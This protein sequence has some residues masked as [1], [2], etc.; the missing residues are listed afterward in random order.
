MLRS[1]RARW[2]L[3]PVL[4]QVGLAWGSDSYVAELSPGDAFRA[5]PQIL[6]P[7]LD[8]QGFR[9][10]ANIAGRKTAICDVWWSKQIPAQARSAAPQNLVYGALKTGAFL[11]V[12]SYLAD[13]ED[14]Q[15][16]MVKAG[17]YTM[18]YAELDQN[19]SEQA[20]SPYRDFAILSP[21]WA[22]RAADDIVP[23]EELTKRSRFVSH[24]DGPAVLS[25]VPVNPA[26]KTVPWAVSDDRGF[27]T[28]QVRL[29]QRTGTQEKDMPFA[30]VLVRPPYEN[31][32]S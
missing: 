13:R 24:D 30:I 16:H 7:S 31:E 22:D 25:L 32:G 3:V 8:P 1:F 10:V 9:L 18:R 26:Y 5:V 6:A 17:M 27:C 14:F 15:H 11:G 23:L 4:L 12:I 28:L 2:L 21:I 29:H 19:G 20:I